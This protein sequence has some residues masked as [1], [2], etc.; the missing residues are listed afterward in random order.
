MSGSITTSRESPYA[1]DGG[2]YDVKVVWQRYLA[3]VAFSVG[4]GGEGHSLRRIAAGGIKAGSY[5]V[6]QPVFGG[7]DHHTPGPA[8]RAVRPRLAS[9]DAGGQVGR[10]G[11]L[12]GTWISVYEVE[13]AERYAPLPQPP[14]ALRLDLREQDA[15]L[16]SGDARGPVP[17]ALVAVLVGSRLVMLAQLPPAVALTRVMVASRGYGTARE[18][19]YVRGVVGVAVPGALF[20]HPPVAALL[21]RPFPPHRYAVPRDPGLEVELRGA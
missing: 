18:T 5:G 4:D 14:D 16:P 10:C 2:F 3:L 6:R 9:S 20:D 21:P 12:A 8:L 17:V 13:L 15:V 11:A 19:D 1:L 7:E